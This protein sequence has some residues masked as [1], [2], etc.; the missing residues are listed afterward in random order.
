MNNSMNGA[1]KN[2]ITD[3][4]EIQEFERLLRSKLPWWA[5]GCER[6]PWYV[7][8]ASKVTQ[9]L[10]QLPRILYLRLS[11]WYRGKTGIQRP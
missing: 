4:L 11:V 7:R 10:R 1:G 2:T 9:H 3:T 6:P 8:L 5:G